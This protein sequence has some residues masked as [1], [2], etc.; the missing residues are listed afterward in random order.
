MGKWIS[1]ALTLLV[2]FLAGCGVMDGGPPIAPPRITLVE[3]DAG[4][5]KVNVSNVSAEGYVLHW[6]DVST[7][8]GVSAV[9]PWQGDYEHFYQNTGQYTIL[10]LD[11]GDDLVVELEVTVSAVDC[12]ISLVSVE[13]RMI[14]VRYFGRDGVDY[15]V[16][17]GDG[18]SDHV[19]V[20]NATGLLVHRYK[21]S[22]TYYVGMAEIW[23]PMRTHFSVAV[24]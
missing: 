8:Y 5:V 6:G 24:E 11:G 12:H 16:A 18:Y 17:W 23:A 3:D 1:G 10:L 13:N 9:F 7:A 21:S 2:I 14:L 4:W 20:F 22:G 19:V 15:S